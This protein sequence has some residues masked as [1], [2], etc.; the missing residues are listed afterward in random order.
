MSVL[1]LIPGLYLGTFVTVEYV[2]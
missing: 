1:Y 2:A